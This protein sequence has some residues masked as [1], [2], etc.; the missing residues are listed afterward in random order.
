MLA[1]HLQQS[2]TA[3]YPLFIPTEWLFFLSIQKFMM[4]WRE[5]HTNMYSPHNAPVCLLHALGHIDCM[6]KVSAVQIWTGGMGAEVH[7]HADCFCAL[8][9]VDVGLC[10]WMIRFWMSQ[11]D[12]DEYTK[13]VAFLVTFK[14]SCRGTAYQAMGSAST[15]LHC[16]L[17][18][19]KTSIWFCAK[20]T[21]AFMRFVH[22]DRFFSQAWTW[23]LVIVV[24]VSMKVHSL[25][26]L[27]GSTYTVYTDG[28]VA[29]N[30]HHFMCSGKCLIHQS[31]TQTGTLLLCFEVDY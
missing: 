14:N 15:H 25:W 31:N 29:S 10:G 24:F 3:S 5:P 23:C 19:W 12:V 9:C 17:R 27:N 8:G 21:Y 18:V 20:T 30:K 26:T 22:L 1:I 16:G 4:A 13:C 2:V 28:K 7:H 6:I 11:A